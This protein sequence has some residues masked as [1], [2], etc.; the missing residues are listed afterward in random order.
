MQPKT[1]AEL[2]AYVESQ[3][4]SPAQSG[5]TEGKGPLLKPGTRVLHDAFGE[6]IVLSRERSGKDIKLVVTFSR[7]GKKSLMER[8]AKLRVMR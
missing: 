6:G 2:R 5:D 1:I 8:Y 7:V 4:K 3:Q